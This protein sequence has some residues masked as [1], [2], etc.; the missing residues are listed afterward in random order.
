[1]SKLRLSSTAK[2]NSGY[3]MP[4]LGFG[5]RV[6]VYQIPKAQATDIC[7]EALR[8][9]YRHID[10]ASAYHNQ[11]ASGASVAAAGVARGEVFFAT[12]IPM[13]GHPLGYDSTHHLVDVALGETQLGY[14]DLVLIHS[15]YGGAEARRGA[16]RALVEC[17][18]A[19]KVRSLGVSNYGVQHLNELEQYMGELEAQRKG[20]G[21]VLSVGQWELHPWLKRDDI[22]AWCRARNVAV[23]AYCPLVHGERFGDT[24]VLA[25]AA[26]YAKTEAQILLRWS[27]QKGYAPL[28]K[29]VRPARIAENADVFGFELSDDDVKSLETGQYMPCAWDPTVEALDK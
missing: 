14:L 20:A 19:G 23:E 5:V 18:E 17:V 11:G 28:V 26:K 10:S 27:L 22:V 13:R 29:S 7:K 2:L 16:W 24:K 9:G 12:K 25:V 8:L 6:L 21:G 15:P 4:L 1:M 3:E